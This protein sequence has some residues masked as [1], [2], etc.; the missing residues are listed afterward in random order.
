MYKYIVI[1]LILIYAKITYACDLDNNSI[2]ND[3]LNKAYSMIEIN[4]CF[5]TEYNSCDKL[6]NAEYQK[7][8]KRANIKQKQ[9]LKEMEKLWLKFMELHCSIDVDFTGRESRLGYNNCKINEIKHRI[10]QLMNYFI[11]EEGVVIK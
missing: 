8:M 2:L 1:F 3:C 5:T 6:L 7:A 10:K 9:E 11:Y 4:N